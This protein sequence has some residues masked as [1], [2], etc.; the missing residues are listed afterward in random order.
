MYSG[1][2]IYLIGAEFVFK[3]D[4][5]TTATSCV[6]KRDCFTGSTSSVVKYVCFSGA[7]S[8]LFRYVIVLFGAVFHVLNS[9]VTV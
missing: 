5:F 2:I 7:T 6:V 3:F 8:C 9:S 4:G 1:R